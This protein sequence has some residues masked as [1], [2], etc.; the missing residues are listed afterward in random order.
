[1]RSQRGHQVGEVFQLGPAAPKE[2]L[3]FSLGRKVSLHCTQGR[4]QKEGDTS[5]L[6]SDRVPAR[7]TIHVHRTGVLVQT[8]RFGSPDLRE[9]GQA[10]ASKHAALGQCAGAYKSLL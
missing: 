9:Q 6:V 5:M 1:M 8:R 2:T 3:R 7:R 10:Q 4:Q